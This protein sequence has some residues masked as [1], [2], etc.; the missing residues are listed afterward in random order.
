MAAQ[1]KGLGKLV[2]TVEVTSNANLVRFIAAVTSEQV[3][4]LLSVLDGG[5]GSAQSPPPP[6]GSAGSA[7]P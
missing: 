5:E 2:D 3:N 7:G 4:Q 6:S 1:L